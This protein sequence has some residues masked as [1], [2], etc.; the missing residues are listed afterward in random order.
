MALVAGLPA[1]PGLVAPPRRRTS[2]LGALIALAA[3]LTALMVLVGGCELKEGEEGIAPGQ[4]VKITF[5]HTTDWHSRLVPY[6]FE[7]TRADREMGIEDR[8]A[9]F[10]G[11]ARMAYLIKR[12]R[13]KAD[14]SL[15]LDSGD[16]FQGAPIFNFFQGEV[17]I[18]AL[19]FLAPDAH[20]MG[21]HDF[22]SGSRNLYAKLAENARYPILAANYR[23]LSSDDPKGIY[24][25]EIVRPF[26]IRNVHGLKVGIIGMG[27]ISSMTSVGE[28]GNSLGIQPMEENQVLQGWIDFLEPQ[29]D[30]VVLL[31]HLGLS[32]DQRIIR[33]TR[34]LDL[35]FGGHHHVVLNPPKVIEDLA[36]RGVPLIHSG[37][38]AK[39][40][41]VLDAVV[42]DGDVVATE[43]RI[44]PVDS[45]V[46]ED[47]EALQLIEPYL[48]D[49]NRQVDLRRVVAYAPKRIPRYGKATGDSALGNL[50]SEAMQKRR[51]VETDFALTNSLGIRADFS[52]GPISAELLFNVFPFENYVTKMMLSGRE[53][54]E[55]LDFVAQ[56]SATRGCQSQAQ[57]A[58]MR[59]KM[60]CLLDEPTGSWADEVYL[61]QHQDQDGRW[62]GGE[63]IVGKRDC[64]KDTGGISP[65]SFE[66]AVNDY[67]ARGGSGFR[68]LKA[69]TSKV[70]TG[71]AIRTVVQD[72]LRKLP[73]CGTHCV[74]GGADPESCPLLRGCV[75]R[76]T[77]YYSETCRIPWQ[78]CSSNSDCGDGKQCVDGMCQRC[79]E[80]GCAEK[81]YT[82]TCE[83][84]ADCGE[85]ELCDPAMAGVQQGVDDMRFC[86]RA[87]CWEEAKTFDST[88]SP[89]YCRADV[90][91]ACVAEWRIRAMD[92]CPRLPCVTVEEDGRI[93]K[94]TQT[95]AEV[96]ASCLPE[97]W[98]T[99]GQA[100]EVDRCATEGICWE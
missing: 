72:F 78:A 67:I 64:V 87:D 12:E 100:I 26:V 32:E 62:V 71:I 16:V 80:D 85:G 70:Q 97:D 25:G 3:G 65:L 10:G 19:S 30:L 40:L 33:E 27:N 53:I 91:P 47:R 69:N 74:D 88:S 44:I 98:E 38:F 77:E 55:M 8:Y 94:I 59:F 39:F 31:S 56:R 99:Q 22:D 4:A 89:F 42:K 43:Y 84:D 13:A 15:Y 86:Y 46:P 29:V 73:A 63:P 45:R 49:M 76:L 93:T 79:D 28:G 2:S 6:T 48:I 9:P 61:G 95:L 20:A 23:F 60:H 1:R 37:A 57:I 11:L 18:K 90:D 96:P 82:P 68:M 34:G 51:Q 41:C 83:S 36:G 52:P 66:V 7:P 54:V 75:E 24:L 92:E 50:V 5:I 21:N 35:V 14:R 81:L 17:E 58:G